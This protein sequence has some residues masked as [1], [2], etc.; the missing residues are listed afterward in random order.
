MLNI[1]SKELFEGFGEFVRKARI[2]KEIPQWELGEALN[3]TQ[4]YISHIERGE[5]VVDLFLAFRICD[6]LNV[7]I[8]EFLTPYIDK[9]EEVKVVVEEELENEV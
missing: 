2:E 1:N 7:D 9:T 3:V 6:Q 5:R 4:A 8:R